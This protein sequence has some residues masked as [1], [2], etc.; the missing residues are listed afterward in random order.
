MNVTFS[1]MLD[2]A[3]ADAIQRAF[4]YDRWC[5]QNAGDADE[6]ARNIF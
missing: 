1:N 5:R 6:I 2:A 3:E 4:L